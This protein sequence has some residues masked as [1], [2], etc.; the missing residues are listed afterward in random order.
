MGASLRGR[1]ASRLKSP[2]QATKEDSVNPIRQGAA[3]IY[4][5]LIALFAIGVV[6]QF[7]FAGAGVFG[8]RPDEDETVSESRFED[9]FDLHSGLGGFLVLASLLLL[10]LILIAWTG[11][12]SIGATFVLF[13]LMI[14]Q[15]ALSGGDEWVGA[16]HPINGLLILGLSS[17]LARRAW[18]GN[19]LVPPSELR[20]TSPPPAPAP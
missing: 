10:I 19:L 8:A 17:F 14:I 12:R 11:P 6:V 13:V 9:K 5:V 7:F 4:R 20:A 18:R 16:F 15:Q 1:P 3:W 2:D